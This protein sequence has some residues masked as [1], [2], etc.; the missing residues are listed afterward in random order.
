MNNGGES[1]SNMCKVLETKRTLYV[2]RRRE[3]SESL[4]LGELCGESIESRKTARTQIIR[5]PWK[6]VISDRCRNVLRVQH[7]QLAFFEYRQVIIYLQGR[8]EG[9]VR[10]FLEGA[11]IDADIWLYFLWGSMG[12]DSKRRDILLDFFTPGPLKW[13]PRIRRKMLPV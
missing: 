10:L 3:R 1:E 2:H 8:K 5:K 7:C 13:E 4:E 9:F 12:I 6:G 11:F